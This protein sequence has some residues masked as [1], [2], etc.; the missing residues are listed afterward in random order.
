MKV[1][2]FRCSVCGK[3]VY[4][5]DE[6]VTPMICCEK[7]MTELIPN[8]HDAV[9]EKHC[10]VC[11]V[12]EGKVHVFVGELTHPM[13]DEHYIEWICLVT[14]AGVMFKFLKPEMEPMACF[15]IGKLEKIKGVYAFCNIHMLWVNENN[16]NKR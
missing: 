8:S 16:F 4:V 7:K 13:N 1:K 6:T 12:S 15:C 9:V 5:L 14:D 2:F 3:V 11:N 10:P